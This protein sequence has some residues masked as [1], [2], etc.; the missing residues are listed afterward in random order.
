MYSK[1]EY[2]IKILKNRDGAMKNSTQGYDI[3][4]DYMRITE[5]LTESSTSI[6]G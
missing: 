6:F 2:K 5:R 1:R 4:Y 3:D